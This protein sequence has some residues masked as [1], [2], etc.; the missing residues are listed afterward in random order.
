MTHHQL[1]LYHTHAISKS[2]HNSDHLSK[3]QL[4][5]IH[6]TPPAINT[7]LKAATLAPRPH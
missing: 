4:N 2:I 5:Q 6:V 3:F 1:L 7:T